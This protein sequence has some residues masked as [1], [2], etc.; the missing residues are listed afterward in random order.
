MNFKVYAEAADDELYGA[1]P[2]ICQSFQIQY[3]DGEGWMNAYESSEQLHTVNYPDYTG[4]WIW[5]QN[6]SVYRGD[7]GSVKLTDYTVNFKPVSS[8]KIRLY[9][10]NAPVSYTHLDVY[11]RQQLY[12]YADG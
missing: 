1:A 10:D 8:S 5:D 2:E 4:S 7:D 3:W 6:S 9:S 11:K 12:L